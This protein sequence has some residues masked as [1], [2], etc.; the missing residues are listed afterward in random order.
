MKGNQL[1]KTWDRIEAWL[2]RH[3]PDILA[4]LCDGADEADLRWAEEQIG[5]TFPKSVRESY[6]I[7]DGA[8]GVALLGYWDFLSVNQMVTAWK[9]L[10]QCYDKRY[11]APEPDQLP[12]G[13]GTPKSPIQPHWWNR[14]WIPFTESDGHHF[15]MDL[16]P[17]DGGVA[18]Q[19]LMWDRA[20]G[21][22]VLLGESFEG[23]WKQFAADLESGVRAPDSEGVLVPQSEK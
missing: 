21:D 22:R 7:H 18:G 10:K 12:E 6:L 15:C 8:D 3:A 17:A 19:V 23:W 9:K 4:E 16:D 1:R 14:K 2:S 5:V 11:F 20:M 13:D